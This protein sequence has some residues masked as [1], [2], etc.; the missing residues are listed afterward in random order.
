LDNIGIIVLAAGASSRLGRPKQLLAFDGQTLLQHTLQAAVASNAGPVVVVLG[1][2]AD[3]IKK[4][5]ADAFVHVVEN[6]EW[7]EGM[8]SSI[9]CGLKTLLEISP[10][11][12]GA[13]LMVCDQPYVNP[14]LLNKLIATHQATGK[15][16]VACSYG[17]TVGPP[18]LF[19]AS[20]FP[21][22]LRLKGDVGARSILREQAGE[23]EAIS[24]PEGVIDVDTE[25]D[26]E[27]LSG[28]G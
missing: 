17:D 10:S 26:Y 2:Q 18:A 21:E 6:T 27:K 23:V 22:L 1:A 24:F 11:A 16:M 12:Q 19:H 5:I 3:L 13:V 7:P 25:Q 15:P 20:V 14:A 9:R 8:A 4:G 28:G